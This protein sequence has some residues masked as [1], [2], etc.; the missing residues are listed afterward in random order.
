MNATLVEF[1]ET[2]M[3][4]SDRDWWRG[5]IGGSIA[6][7]ASAGSGFLGMG[8]AH[9]IGMDVQSPNLQAL[10]VLL[11]TSGLAAALTYLKQSPLP[12]SHEETQKTDDRTRVIARD[13][14]ERTIEKEI[15]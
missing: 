2:V 9:S 10:A 1:I 8:L 15:I 3:R 12:P 13:E 6:S 11:F 4:K 5:L 7:A 14:I